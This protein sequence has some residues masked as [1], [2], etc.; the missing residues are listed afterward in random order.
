M[1]TGYVDPNANGTTIEWSPSAGTNYEC[2]DDG[3]REPNAPD[4]SDYVNTGS[5]GDI[6]E[7]QMTTLTGADSITEIKVWAYVKGFGPDPFYMNIYVDGAWQTEQSVT[8]SDSWA[9]YSATFSGSWSQSDLD[10]LQ[11][12]IKSGAA[13][14]CAA[15][16]AEITYTATA[17]TVSTFMKPI[18]SW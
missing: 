8:I 2:V 10:A 18:K 3:V 17:P 1:A 5:G 11:V 7:Y 15:V 6:D 13:E 4:T 16:Y 14:D 9:W 12:R